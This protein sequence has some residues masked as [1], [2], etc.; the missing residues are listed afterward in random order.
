MATDLL[1]YQHNIDYFTHTGAHLLQNLRTATQQPAVCALQELFRTKNRQPINLQ[2][3][4]YRHFIT[5]YGRACLLVHHNFSCSQL[6]IPHHRDKFNVHG[7]E[8][9]WV[10]VTLPTG[11]KIVF[12]S[13]YRKQNAS[14][15]SLH[16]L[17]NE[18]N[19][20]LKVSPF[21]MIL[22]DINAH[23]PSWFSDRSHSL[24]SKIAPTIHDDFLLENGLT[25]LNQHDHRITFT[26]PDQNVN[27]SID[28]SLTSPACLQLGITSWTTDNPHFDLD[29]PHLP[30]T[31][32][33]PFQP[34]SAHFCKPQVH[35]YWNC[36]SEN[37][38]DYTISVENEL[39]SFYQTI[40]LH[41]T[42]NQSTLNDLISQFTA[43]LIQCAKTTVGE[44]IHVPKNKPWYNPNLHKLRKRL[45][46]A[47]KQYR[48]YRTS[49]AREKLQ[50]LQREYNKKIKATKKL[51]YRR[52]INKIH[53]KW[54][55]LNT[56]KMFSNY[57]HIWKPTKPIY[58]PLQL[59]DPNNPTKHHTYNDPKDK[60]RIFNQFF[61]A[62]PKPKK[63]RF[64]HTVTEALRTWERAKLSD[65]ESTFRST[66]SIY[67]DISEFE[68]ADALRHLNRYK[69]MGSDRIHNLMLICG[70]EHLINCLTL[71]FNKC[72]KT[73][74]FPKAWK[75]STILPIPKPGRDDYT[76]T[77]NYRPISLLSCVGKLFER[78]LGRRL[79][80]YL[81]DNQL[82]DPK[83]TGFLPHH[84][85]LE[86]L[87]FLTEQIFTDFH[88]K[89]STHCVFLD[90]CKAYDRVWLDGLRYKLRSEFKL[91]GCFYWILDS[92][93]DERF[94]RTDVQ[95]YLSPYYPVQIG[96][97]QGSCLSPILFIMYINKIHTCTSKGVHSANFA[98]DIYLS[99]RH[100]QYDLSSITK[101]CD[102]VQTSLTAMSKWLSDWKLE[103]SADKCESLE[104]CQ[105]KNHCKYQRSYYLYGK[106]LKQVTE[107]KLL[108]VTL[109]QHLTFN[110]HLDNIYS[111]ACKRLGHLRF[112][113]YNA[114]IRLKLKP[115][116]I[117]YNTIV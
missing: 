85:T 5:D 41:H 11:T 96:I 32:R 2:N 99:T 73:G 10:V 14:N 55:D 48:K 3:L 58:G 44:V 80:W 6:K 81:L 70:D 92:F 7:F 29:S 17:Q 20:A 115:Y 83:Q 63:S 43:I 61:T 42:L 24:K 106:K 116:T 53:K 97:P 19:L 90:I 103:F 76:Q 9:I 16:V 45:N 87:A 49:E 102:N 79:I 67:S 77:K 72:F 50:K 13:L 108:G 100:T 71:I 114:T 112:H 66:D 21:V 107:F 28:L 117:F 12:C 82:I 37:W 88:N 1:I 95:G 111:T 47:R 113:M 57:K 52:R 23:H 109:D 27:T 110:H 98:D 94:A 39:E 34:S 65:L 104:F 78:V 25:I 18:Y 75:I 86:N 36:Y 59:P 8:S 26:I 51:Y 91:H 64:D 40:P 68:V 62:I 4:P 69:A 89:T 15:I 101:N 35:R 30:I 31:F 93:L 38:N 84:S 60:A 54:T 46:K 33:I 56:K 74:Y 105:R 22:A